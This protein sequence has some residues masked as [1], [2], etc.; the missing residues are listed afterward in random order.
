MRNTLSL[1]PRINEWHHLMAAFQERR[2]LRGLVRWATYQKRSS[3]LSTTYRRQLETMQ[4]IIRAYWRRHPHMTL[5]GSLLFHL[6]TLLGGRK[7][8]RKGSAHKYRMNN[9]KVIRIGYAES[10]A[11]WMVK[12]AGRRVF[13][14]QARWYM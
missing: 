12:F 6:M 3:G 1:S 8:A 2:Q 7:R 10:Q 14:R 11:Q 5:W 4:R 9:W 13:G